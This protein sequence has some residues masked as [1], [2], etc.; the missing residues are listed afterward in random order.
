[1]SHAAKQR[2]PRQ[3]MCPCG[4]PSIGRYSNV[5]CCERCLAIE[6]YLRSREERRRKELPDQLAEVADTF[7]YAL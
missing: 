1:M 7:T 6:S 3:E 2:L 4:R 5:P